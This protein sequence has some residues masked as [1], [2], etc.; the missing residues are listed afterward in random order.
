M[1]VP[2][3]RDVPPA[4]TCSTGPDRHKSDGL[5]SL[6]RLH[7]NSETPCRPGPGARSLS[8]AVKPDDRP[9]PESLTRF[10]AAPSL[11]AARTS[12]AECRKRPPARGSAHSALEAALLRGFVYGVSGLVWLVVLGLFVHHVA[13]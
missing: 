4:S 5:P 2:D 10:L 1:L 6:N 12:P 11:P 3:G 13:R 8:G 9:L 7:W